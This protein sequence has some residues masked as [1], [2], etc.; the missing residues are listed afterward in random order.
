MNL[1]RRLFGRRKTPAPPVAVPVAPVAVPTLPSLE[2]ERRHL[3]G[4][5]L[6]P[7]DLD[8]TNRLNFQHFALRSAIE[9]NYL[10]PI[11]NPREILDV[12]TGS[13]I[14]SHELAQEFPSAKVIGL[15]LE[16]GKGVAASPP[17]FEFVQGNLLEGLPFED[18]R[19]DFVHQRLLIGALPASA[20][21]LVI[22]DLARVTRPGGWVELV[23]SDGDGFKPAGP[24]TEK[25]TRGVIQIAARMGIDTRITATLATLMKDAGL[26]NVQSRILR[27]PVG[28]WGGRLGSLM[29]TDMA[30]IE[31]SFK[32]GFLKLLNYT[33]QE[34]DALLDEVKQEWETYHSSY[35]FYFY[36]GQ[37]P[38]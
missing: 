1:F 33:P 23:E 34:F 21:P 35:I 12:G 8:E 38:R 4:H 16:E 26:V 7:K 27:M 24:A 9:V 18:D 6:L 22:K 28:E 10:A 30:A 37:K 20:W 29:K 3:D 5:Y 13:A 14:W 36:V 25:I 32:D 11:A 2:V 19:F 17:N 31:M 15:D